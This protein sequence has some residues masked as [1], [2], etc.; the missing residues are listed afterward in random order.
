M[1]PPSAAASWRPGDVCDDTVYLMEW[2][3]ETCPTR[4]RRDNIEVTLMRGLMKSRARPSR[5][6]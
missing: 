1:P 4:G 2:A 3:H 6:W 5:D